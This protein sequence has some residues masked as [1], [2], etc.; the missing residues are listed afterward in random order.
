VVLDDVGLARESRETAGR[1]GVLEVGCY[2]LCM[3]SDGLATFWCTVHGM[4]R[5]SIDG[6]WIYLSEYEELVM[7]MLFVYF[8]MVL[9]CLFALLCNLYIGY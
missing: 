3:G 7:P 8:M 2:M 4:S 1:Q 9:W 6:V 5:I